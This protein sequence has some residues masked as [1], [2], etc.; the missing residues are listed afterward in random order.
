MLQGVNP[1]VAH[2]ITELFLLSPSNFCGQHVGKGFTHNT[3]LD[4]KAGFSRI[5]GFLWATH[6]CLGVG[7]HGNIE[8]LL[9]EEGYATLYTPSTQALIGTQAII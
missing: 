8:K 2:P 7:T 6:L 5:S 4:F 3:L 1:G 9:V